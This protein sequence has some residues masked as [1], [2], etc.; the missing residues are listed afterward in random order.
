MAADLLIGVLQTGK[1][2]DVRCLLE[3]WLVTRGTTGPAPHR[4]TPKVTKSGR[5]RSSSTAT[6]T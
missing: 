4:R 5:I 1:H 3:T 6:T 2:G